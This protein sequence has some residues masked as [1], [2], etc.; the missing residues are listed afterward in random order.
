MAGREGEA[1]FLHDVE[2]LERSGKQLARARHADKGN[3]L[4]E[5]FHLMLGIMRRHPHDP[6]EMP[7][8]RREIADRLR[9][10][11]AD[12]GIQRQPAKCLEIAGLGIAA[13]E[14][15]EACAFREMVLEDRTAHVALV[16]QLR[17]LEGIP[18]PLIGVGPE[19]RMK[20]DRALEDRVGQVLVDRWCARR[21]P[22]GVI[23][24]PGG[25]GAVGGLRRCVERNQ[26]EQGC[27]RDPASARDHRRTG[28]RRSRPCSCRNWDSRSATATLFMSAKGRCVLPCSPRSGRRRISAWPPCA[29][30]IRTNS[31]ESL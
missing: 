21:G 2:N 10:Q 28:E 13:D 15:G 24:F 6:R 25:A 31:C 26:D 8:H 5:R 20:V 19:M 7:F 11:A 29:L 17:D 9:I 12:L 4:V 30:T 1:L 18:L 14:K 16:H 22:V 27:R 23:G 3:G